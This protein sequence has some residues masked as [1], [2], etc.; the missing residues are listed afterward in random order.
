MT[1]RWPGFT[2][3]LERAWY[4]ITCARRMKSS[5]SSLST[6]QKDRQQKIPNFGVT[7]T[8]VR[9]AITTCIASTKGHTTMVGKKSQAIELAMWRYHATCYPIFLLTMFHD[10]MLICWWKNRLWPTFFVSPL[11]R[12]ASFVGVVSGVFGEGNH[13]QRTGTCPAWTVDQK[14][15]WKILPCFGSDSNENGANTFFR[16][17]NKCNKHLAAFPYLIATSNANYRLLFQWKKNIASYKKSL[18][19]FSHAINFVLRW[20]RHSCVGQKR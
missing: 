7:T 3:M 16:F 13:L 8:R 12:W 2:S 17:A 14:S 11:F 15:V 5:L 20:M 10:A 4:G 9:F 1:A 18:A 6:S 19:P